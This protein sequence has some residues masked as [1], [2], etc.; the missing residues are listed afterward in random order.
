MATPPPAS[1]KTIKDTTATV[2][3]ANEAVAEAT[4]GTTDAV[5]SGVKATE[6]TGAAVVKAV[7]DLGKSVATPPVVN[8]TVAAPVIPI[9]PIDT[10]LK[11]ISKQLMNAVGSLAYEKTVGKVLGVISPL[12]KSLDG[13]RKWS[14]SA[15][16]AKMG[17]GFLGK[18][19]KFKGGEAAVSSQME[20]ALQK[21]GKGNVDLV[22]M[23]SSQ[24]KS[25]LKQWSKEEC[26]NS[27]S[28]HTSEEEWF[29]DSPAIFD[30]ALKNGWIDECVDAIN[31]NSDG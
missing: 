29:K 11:D 9:P 1:D 4:T 10:S 5:K 15:T 13:I 21:I 19:N 14:P 30:A 23:T 8:V 31:R 16:M 12:G 27:A 26:L 20:K 17:Q 2:V 24:R 7:G 3:E 28:S 25:T 22:S 18:L 6:K